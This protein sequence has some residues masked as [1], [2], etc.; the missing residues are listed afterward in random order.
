MDLRRIDQVRE[1]R[2][3]I[4][5][6]D[7]RDVREMPHVWEQMRDAIDQKLKA[8]ASEYGDWKDRSK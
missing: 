6:M 2:D 7:T 4:K 5:R 3:E 8:A 1:L